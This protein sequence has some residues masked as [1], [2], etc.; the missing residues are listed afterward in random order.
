MLCLEH[1]FGLL[2]DVADHF[3][4]RA[5]IIISSTCGITSK[6]TDRLKVNRAYRRRQGGHEHHSHLGPAAVCNGFELGLEERPS[7]DCLV[8]I[9][10]DSIKLQED[11][12]QP[13]ILQLMGVIAIERQANA[14]R[15]EL[16]GTETESAYTANN[17]RQVAAHG[18]LAAGKM[19][20]EWAPEFDQLAAPAHDLIGAR[21]RLGGASG[22]CK[23]NRASQVASLRNIEDH[24]AGVLAMLL[25]EAAVKGAPSFHGVSHTPAAVPE[26]GIRRPTHCK[27]PHRAR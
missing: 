15:I 14:V 2:L 6:I 5:A 1:S 17:F 22:R 3:G 4:K 19:K 16:N 27:N 13:G 9:V 12:G 25:A 8:D 20:I 10:A 21:I 7:A 26:Y 18:R 24:A 11:A 23:T